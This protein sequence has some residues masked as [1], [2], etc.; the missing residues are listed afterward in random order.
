VGWEIVKGNSVNTLTHTLLTLTRWFLPQRCLGCQSI[1][2]QRYCDNCLSTIALHAE[3]HLSNSGITITSLAPYSK[4]LKKL[5]QEIKFSGQAQTADQLGLWIANTLAPQH[6]TP[7]TSLIEL[8]RNREPDCFAML[9]NST[10]M[11]Y[12]NKNTI[13]IPIPSDATRST[14]R[15]FHH[16]EKLFDPLCT[17]WEIPLISAVIRSKDTTAL[18]HLGKDDRWAETENA[19]TVILPD[20]VENKQILILDD[21]LTTGATMDAMALALIKAGAKDVSGLVLATGKRL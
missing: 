12:H 10:D 2:E 4:T 18:H 21:I 3:T 13:A 9:P 15:G 1:S 5:L 7:E 19:F 17:S 14:Q 11:P 20:I 6:I 16:V 8:L